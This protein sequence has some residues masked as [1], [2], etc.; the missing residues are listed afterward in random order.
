MD[1]RAVRLREDKLMKVKY[2]AAAL[3]IKKGDGN[4]DELLMIQRAKNDMWPN[5]WEFPR[6]GCEPEKDKSL[7]DCIIREVKEET[8]LDVKPIK[9][10]VKEK[11][12][13]ENENEVTYCYNYVCKMLKPDQEIHLSREHRAYK[14][15][16]EVGEVELMATPDQKKIIQRVL[17]NERS[18]VSYPRHQ[19]VEEGLDFYLKSIQE[20][21]SAVVPN[22]ISQAAPVAAKG[23]L[24]S[25]TS[26]LLPI[27]FSFLLLKM[28][29]DVYKNNFTAA[30]KKCKGYGAG[31]KQI[32]M[33]RAQTSAKKASLEKLQTNIDKCNKDKAPE[34]CRAK[35]GQKIQALQQEI[36][37]LMQREKELRGKA[38][39][40]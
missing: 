21:A 4:V 10:I 12:E 3:I 33:L 35:I 9:F 29:A 25:A 34:N 18:I 32:C 28:A 37:Y 16:S 31:E 40:H 19:K 39:I 24:A 15:I 5:E 23:M 17:N 26:T 36:G 2:S 8:G 14:W 11:L 6:G 38:A 1:N 30:A 13:G 20:Q 7:K 22:V 27:Y